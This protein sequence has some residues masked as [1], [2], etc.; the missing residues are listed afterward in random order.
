MRLCFVPRGL[1][2]MPI[3]KLT[4]ITGIVSSGHGS[5]SFW[6]NVKT[7]ET[8]R[9]WQHLTADKC[10]HKGHSKSAGKYYGGITSTHFPNSVERSLQMPTGHT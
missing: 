9:M 4:E 10:S 5:T 3:Q 8:V 2:F 7:Q 6:G 1:A